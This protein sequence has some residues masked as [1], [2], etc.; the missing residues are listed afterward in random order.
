MIYIILLAIISAIC[1]IV[2]GILFAEDSGFSTML[3]FIGGIC[4][5]LANLLSFQ[6]VA[7]YILDTSI[8]PVCQERYEKSYDYCPIDGAKLEFSFKAI[9]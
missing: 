6:E 2:G 9:E 3:I 1:F 8:C 7:N 4:I 5:F